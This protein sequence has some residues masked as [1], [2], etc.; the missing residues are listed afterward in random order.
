MKEKKLLKKGK[1]YFKECKKYKNYKSCRDS[2]KI[3]W[4]DSE[5]K[6]K[7]RQKKVNKNIKPMKKKV[8]KYNIKPHKK[9]SRTQIEKIK[10][11]NLDDNEINVE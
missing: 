3:N 1:Y 8:M 9:K 2:I 5:A 7:I 4:V 11:M 10:M 6:A